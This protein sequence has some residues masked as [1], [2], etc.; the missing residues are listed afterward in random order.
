MKFYTNEGSFKK[1]LG[2][3]TLFSLMSMSSTVLA[4]DQQQLGTQLLYQLK[5]QSDS[6]F[7]SP[8]PRYP[9]CNDIVSSA[10]DS[11][12]ASTSNMIDALNASVQSSPQND[13]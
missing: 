13:D 5:G 6:L 12:S 4:D 1:T 3:V 11:I 2:V 9:R 10:S 7:I 8:C